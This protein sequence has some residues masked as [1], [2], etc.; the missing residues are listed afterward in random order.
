MTNKVNNIMVSYDSH[1]EI[2]VGHVLH[3]RGSINKIRN[4]RTL[5]HD[6]LVCFKL[7]TRI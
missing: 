3:L 1:R 4:N 6:R 2:S 7:F 5:M